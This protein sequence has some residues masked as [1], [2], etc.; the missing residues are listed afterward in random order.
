MKKTLLFACVALAFCACVK[1]PAPVPDSVVVILDHCPDQISTTRFGS[2]LSQYAYS[3]ISYVDSTGSLVQYEPQDL[4]KDTLT[5]PAFNGYA[6]LMHLYQA[7]EFDT[8]LL[9]AGDTVLVNYDSRQRPMLTS[10]VYKDLTDIYN[11]PYTRPNA[12]QSLDYFIETVMTEWNFTRPFQYFKD[13]KLRAKHPGLEKYFISRYV[14]LDSLSNVYN[15][16]LAAFRQ[17]V[18]SLEKENRIDAFYADYLRTR[19][20]PDNRFAPEATVQSD[21]LLHYV[22]N[23]VRA[24]AYCLGVDPLAVFD[25]IADDTLVTALA[26]KGIL[27]RQ[28]G[29]I[30]SGHQG[31]HPYSQEV[32]DRYTSRYIQIT[33]DSAYV[34]KV[35]AVPVAVSGSSYNLPLEDR[36]GQTT[37][38]ADILAQNKGKVI[39]V[40]FWASWCGPCRSQLPYSR[41]LQKRLSGKNI[42]FLFLSTDTDRKAWLR[43]VREE[44][45]A[46]ANTYRILDKKA[47]LL[48]ELNVR[49]I[50][51]YVIFDTDG[52]IAE[53]NAERPSSDKIESQLSAY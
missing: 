2:H 11:L 6:E 43:A 17:S 26:R 29:V 7:I 46:M 9:K 50:P 25:K 35:E 21:S 45:G 30:L 49:A 15:E 48:K 4:R 53:P 16:Y 3:P 23:Y 12:I 33:G 28:L 24:Q 8:Y 47:L 32:I 41:E 40:D 38:L 34:Q 19:F 36:N 5:L 1:K 42:V 39:Y 14:D 10:L 52:N 20:I 18:D 37:T 27:K 22:S 31:Y 51:R 13:E 44:A